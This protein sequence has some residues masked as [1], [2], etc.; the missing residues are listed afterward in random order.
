MTIPQ[1]A[2]F[3]V[4]AYDSQ[5]KVLGEVN[6]TQNYQLTWTV[7]VANKKAAYYLFRGM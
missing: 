1:A 5:G 6:S 4:Y 3:R 2:R 7:H